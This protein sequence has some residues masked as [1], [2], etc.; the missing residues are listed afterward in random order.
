M[1]DPFPKPILPYLEGKIGELRM[2]RFWSK[3]DIRAPEECWEWQ[4]SL[5]TSGYGRFKIASHVQVT[6][7]RLALIAHKKDEG[8]GL[9]VL[10]HCDNP[11]CC[12][13]HHLY[14]GTVQD[15][16]NDKV[17]RGRCRSGDQSGANNGAA[18]INEQQ[19]E[20]IVSRFKKGWNNKQIAADLPIGHA[21][22]SKIRCGNMWQ[23]QAAKLGWKPAPQFKR[24]AA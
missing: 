6:A 12:N 17:E 14:F 13:P 15:N 23:E 3:V 11:K 8:G 9:H 16:V 5:T 19:L 1:A 21:M 10:H 7:S 22:V 20:L 4:A 18:K 24:K 2:L